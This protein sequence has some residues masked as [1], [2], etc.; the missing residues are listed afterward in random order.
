MGGPLC[1]HIPSSI[2][3]SLLE[4]P[5]SKGL[6]LNALASPSSSVRFLACLLGGLVEY[7][8]H[9]RE[10]GGKK[11]PAPIHGVYVPRPPVDTQNL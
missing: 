11:S 1:F 4:Y 9:A 10:E 3:A 8:N 7:L 6:L 2:E 5:L